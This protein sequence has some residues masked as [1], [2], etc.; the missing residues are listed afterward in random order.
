MPMMPQGPRGAPMGPNFAPPQRPQAGF[1]PPGRINPRYPGEVGPQR[2]RFAHAGAVDGPG[3]GRD[4]AVNAR[5]SDGEYVMDAETVALLGDG[6]NKAGAQRLDEL[7]ARLRE[8]KGQALTRGEFSPNA[9][10][11]EAYLRGGR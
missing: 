2:A 5:L 9:R 3:N 10:T 11:P 7:R 4:D 8:H 1:S 6:S